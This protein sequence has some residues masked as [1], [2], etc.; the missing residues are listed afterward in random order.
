MKKK[1]SDTVMALCS[2]GHFDVVSKISQNVFKL[3]FYV[4]GV[5]R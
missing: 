3:G 1:N 5:E 4:H 2:S